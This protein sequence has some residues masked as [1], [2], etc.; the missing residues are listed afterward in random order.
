MLAE[1][2]VTIKRM[3]SVQ[4]PAHTMYRLWTR[5]VCVCVCAYIAPLVLSPEALHYLLAHAVSASQNAGSWQ[6]LA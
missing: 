3:L 2:T 5:S 1:G 6:L 4:L